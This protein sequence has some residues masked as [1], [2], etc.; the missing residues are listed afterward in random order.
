MESVILVV[1]TPSNIVV[2]FSNAKGSGKTYTMG[3]ASSTNVE[4]TKLGII[5]RVITELFEAAE[6]CCVSRPVHVC[7]LTRFVHVA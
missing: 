2:V 1:R 4:K 6:V 5:P 3:T 7:F